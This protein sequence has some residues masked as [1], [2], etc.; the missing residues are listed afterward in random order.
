MDMNGQ[1]NTNTQMSTSFSEHIKQFAK[2][3]YRLTMLQK[4][5]HLDKNILYFILF[6]EIHLC[7]EQMAGRQ[8]YEI[9]E[10]YRDRFV[11]VL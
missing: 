10:H 6:D 7:A 8:L 5:Q 3:E 2:V 11:S 9:N 1:P 4:L